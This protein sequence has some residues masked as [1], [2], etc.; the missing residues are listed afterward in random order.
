M[1]QQCVRAQEQLSIRL[2][3]LAENLYVITLISK[4]K[5]TLASGLLSLFRLN[6]VFL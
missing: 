6:M 1:G 4:G 2:T 3:F 5:R